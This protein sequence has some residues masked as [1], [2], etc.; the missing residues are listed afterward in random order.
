MNIQ[1]IINSKIHFDSNLPADYSRIKPAS[2]MCGYWSIVYSHLFSKCNLT[3]KT[4]NISTERSEYFHIL[5]RVYIDLYNYVDIDRD[6]YSIGDG[7]GGSQLIDYWNY[8]IYNEIGENTIVKVEDILTLNKVRQNSKIQVN[9]KALQL[10]LDYADDF[11]VGRL[12]TSY[13]SLINNVSKAMYLDMTQS[14]NQYLSTQSKLYGKI[15]R[16]YNQLNKL[17]KW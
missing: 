13:P 15:Y 7:L 5:T 14:S 10:L 16:G 11:A 17:F 2:G 9:K 1:N 12:K 3:C 8:N 4:I 6:S